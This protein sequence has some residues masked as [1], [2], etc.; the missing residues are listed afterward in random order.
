M[1]AHDEEVEESE[2]LFYVV[3]AV[4]V[5][6]VALISVVVKWLVVVFAVGLLTIAPWIS[7]ATRFG[8]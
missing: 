6:A 4:Q 3:A 2:G 5:G 1:A 7:D 8:G